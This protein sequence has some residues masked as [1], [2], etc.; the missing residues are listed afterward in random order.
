MVWAYGKKGRKENEL[1]DLLTGRELS[2]REGCCYRRTGNLGVARIYS[3]SFASI[4]YI[5]HPLMRRTDV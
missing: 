5:H 4:R 3:S 1:K 2:E